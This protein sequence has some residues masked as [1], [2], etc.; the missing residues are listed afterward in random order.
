MKSRNATGRAKG[1]KPNLARR[2][3]L[4]VC[5]KYEVKPG[6]SK[7]YTLKVKK[8]E[9]VEIALFNLDGTFYAIS[10]R[11]QHKGGPLSEG[12]IGTNN[13]VTCPWHG[14]QFDVTTG[15][16]VQDPHVGVTRHETRV[17]GDEVQVRLTE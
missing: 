4:Y 8:A 10:E 3:W 17:I 7:K 12:S 1:E 16:L 2:S 6:H 5:E 11:C 9:L 14:W 13:I 15:A